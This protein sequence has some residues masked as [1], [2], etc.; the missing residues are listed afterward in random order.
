MKPAQNNPQPKPNDE[1]PN[2]KKP[3]RICFN[4]RPTGSHQTNGPKPIH[5]W[6][7]QPK[8][9]G[10]NQPSPNNSQIPLLAILIQD[11]EQQPTESQTGVIPVN[12]GKWQRQWLSKTSNNH[13]DS[14]D[15]LSN[16]RKRPKNATILIRPTVLQFWKMSQPIRNC[17]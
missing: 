6:A 11:S 1:E 17:R 14:M 12:S 7:Q 10:P 9:L 8:S 3:Y 5:H 15:T 4:K 2:A 13:H 16:D